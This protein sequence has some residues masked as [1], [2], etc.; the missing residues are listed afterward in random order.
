MYL[1]KNGNKENQMGKINILFVKGPRTGESLVVD[2]N[3]TITFGR[4]K[5]CDIVL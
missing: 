1:K 4:D 2:S 5:K 3:D